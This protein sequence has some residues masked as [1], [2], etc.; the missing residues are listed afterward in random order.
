[1][2]ILLIVP[3]VV[4]G[5]TAESAVVELNVKINETF[6]NTGIRV[7]K[8]EEVPADETGF[9]NLFN[10]ALGFIDYN[11]TNWE[12]A[13][14]SKI[15]DNFRVLVKRD[16]SNKII[17]GVSGTPL[18]SESDGYLSYKLEYLDSSTYEPFY[19]Y[20][21]E[22]LAIGHLSSYEATKVFETNKIRDTRVFKYTIPF[23]ASV[24]FGEYRATI[25]FSITLE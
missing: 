15:V 14:E 1:M 2:A 20:N 6:Q 9:T 17:V 11:H 21:K 7:I 19:E 13:N 18:K 16:A 10:S 8:G 5:E 24:G 23:D 4:F 22:T 3:A 12:D 25:T